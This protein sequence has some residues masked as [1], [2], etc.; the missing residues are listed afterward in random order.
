MDALLSL[1]LVRAWE[2]IAVVSRYEKLP[3]DS[4]GLH[5]F[6]KPKKPTKAASH[7][8]GQH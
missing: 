1:N 2:M 7:T 4:K 3:R 8:V 6:C 5:E